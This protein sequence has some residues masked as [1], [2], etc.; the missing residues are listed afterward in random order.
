MPVT[1]DDVVAA[2]VKTRDTIKF[3]EKKLEDD[4]AP[5]KQLQEAREAYL[6]KQLDANKCQNMKTEHGTVYQSRKESVT[7][8]DWDALLGWVRENEAWEFINKSCNKTSCLEAMG[9]ERTEAPPPGVNYV[10]VRV[11]QIRKS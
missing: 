8:G 1:I 4:L 10:A 2:Y 6:L 9:D 11:A 3:L 7:V 5:L